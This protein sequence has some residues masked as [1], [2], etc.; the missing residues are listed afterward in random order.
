MLSKPLVYPGRLETWYQCYASWC[1]RVMCTL[2][3]G[4]VVRY[5]GITM[6]ASPA[7]FWAIWLLRFWVSLMYSCVLEKNPCA[8]GFFA[9][10][11]FSLST[12]IVSCQFKGNDHVTWYKI[13]TRL[14][15]LEKMWAWPSWQSST[16]HSQWPWLLRTFQATSRKQDSGATPN[17]LYN[18][19]N[20]Q[21]ETSAW[22]NP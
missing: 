14:G 4:M 9:S 19:H 5:Y 11:P 16:V 17:N 3:D 8:H 10:G 15:R 6:P 21:V 22:W 20:R 7:L 1:V 13:C 12:S 18:S 2:S